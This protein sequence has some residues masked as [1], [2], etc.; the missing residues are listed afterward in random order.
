MR[1]F[2]NEKPN[3]LVPK[4]SVEDVAFINQL[5]YEHYQLRFLRERSGTFPYIN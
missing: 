2:R 4:C 1:G 5:L 3:T